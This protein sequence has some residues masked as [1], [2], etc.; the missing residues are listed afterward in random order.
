MPRPLIVRRPENCYHW[1]ACG[2][3]LLPHYLSGVLEHVEK[4][5]K[6]GEPKEKIVALENLPGF[7]DYHTPLPNRLGGNLSVAYDELTER[8]G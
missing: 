5:I 7:P 6:A 1:C 4:K 3:A 2:S 8:R